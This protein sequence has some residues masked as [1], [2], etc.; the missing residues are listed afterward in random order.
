MSPGQ[1]SGPDRARRGI[2]RTSK[3]S[4]GDSVGAP[5]QRPGSEKNM[6]RAA[7]LPGRREHQQAAAKGAGQASSPPARFPAELFAL[8][9]LRS[10]GSGGC[11]AVQQATRCRTPRKKGGRRGPGVRTSR[12]RAR[13]IHRTARSKGPPCA[14]ITHHTQPKTQRMKRRRYC[15][16]FGHRVSRFCRRSSLTTRKAA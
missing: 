8:R 2:R 5:P 15:R 13:G 9:R 1:I 14:P 10:G 12:R 16:I 3:E 4:A 11:V 6:L 7:T